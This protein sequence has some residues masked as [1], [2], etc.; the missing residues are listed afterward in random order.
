M[1][2]AKHAIDVRVPVRTAYNQW[3]QFESFPQF[4]EGVKE[5]RQLDNK[6][7]HWVAEV[8]GKTQEWDAAIT[9]QLPD[10]RV[11]WK[12]TTGDPN[13][14]V[15]TFHYLEP[16]KTRVMLQLDYAPQGVVEG[17]AAALGFLDRRVK[18]DMERFKRFIES[19]GQATGAWRGT[20]EDHPELGH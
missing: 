10:Q 14:G 20:I 12:S 13:S 19:Q 2:E 3:T 18:G 16:D 11:A 17:A 4:M 15:V 9:E 1:A 6:H 5:V 8:G 7:L